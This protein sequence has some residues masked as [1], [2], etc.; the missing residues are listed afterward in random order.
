M[1]DKPVGWHCVE[2]ADSDGAPS[3]EDWLRARDPAVQELK[4]AGLVHRLDRSTS[5][6]LM[7]ARDAETVSDLRE[8]LSVCDSPWAARKTYLALAAKSMPKAGEFDL[9]FAGR[10]KRSAKVTVKAFGTPGDRG[11]CTWRVVRAA[12]DTAMPATPRAFDL[13]EIELIGPGRRHQI[14]AGLAWLGHPLA[15]DQLYGGAQLGDEFNGGCAALHAWRLRVRS[16]TVEAPPP[17][18]AGGAD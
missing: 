4:D 5:G 11:R 8:A 7:V 12:V 17:P 13:V 16:I 14:R 3:V 15:G 6:C 9:H 2:A 1:I 10:H 18:W